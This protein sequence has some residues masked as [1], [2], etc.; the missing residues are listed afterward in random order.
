MSLVA[1]VIAV[2]VERFSAAILAS[3]AVWT[4]FSSAAPD[5]LCALPSRPTKF[6]STTATRTPRIAMTIRSSVSVKPASPLYR[7]CMISPPSFVSAFSR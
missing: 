7:F 5:V 6:G 3:T 4:M 1:I 2:V